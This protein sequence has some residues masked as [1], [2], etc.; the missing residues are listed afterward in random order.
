MPS[1]PVED[2]SEGMK[3]LATEQ[4][5]EMEEKNEDAGKPK[6]RF[7]PSVQDDEKSKELKKA[8]TEQDNK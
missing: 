3:E 1:N 8:V 4:K 2:E 5:N 6:D 7:S